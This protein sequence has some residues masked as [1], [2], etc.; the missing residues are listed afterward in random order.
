MQI[1]WKV[2]FNEFLEPSLSC[3]EDNKSIVLGIIWGVA[4]FS[5]WKQLLKQVQNK[6]Q[7]L[8][9][10]RK[11]GQFNNFFFCFRNIKMKLLQIKYSSL[12]YA[13][14]SERSYKGMHMHISSFFAFVWIKVKGFR[15]L[16]NAG[17]VSQLPSNAYQKN[18]YSVTLLL[19]LVR[20][21]IKHYHHRYTENHCIITR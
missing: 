15:E 13:G 5:S 14:W 20:S 8:Q 21:D 2:Y 9:T 17:I 1:A 18:A 11:R 3:L 7:E 19:T 4:I 12:A 6:M 10:G 16:N